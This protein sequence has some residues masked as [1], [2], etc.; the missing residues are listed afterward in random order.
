M[1]SLVVNPR[2]L[3]PALQWVE[4]ASPIEETPF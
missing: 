3:G 1:E 2:A 4:A